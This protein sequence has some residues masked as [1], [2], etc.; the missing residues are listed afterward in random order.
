MATIGASGPAAEAQVVYTSRASFLAA[1][2][3]AAIETFDGVAPAGGFVGITNLG[4]LTF[5]APPHTGLFVIDPGYSAF[6]EYDSDDV[7]S[8]QRAGLLPSEVTI[9]LGGGFTAF[10]FDLG[11]QGTLYDLL[12]SNGV[13]A[14]TT[15][16]SPRPTLGFLGVVS[17]TAFTS[18]TITADVYTPVIDNVVYGTGNLA[19]VPEPATVA[20][21]AGGLATLGLAT[22]RRHGAP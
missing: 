18:A 10:G 3:G 16:A 13:T 15:A 9:D 2:T 1:V 12:L 22:R 7:F 6:Y 21:L 17:P 19:A 20:L 5:T 4:P 8:P 14:S 11:V